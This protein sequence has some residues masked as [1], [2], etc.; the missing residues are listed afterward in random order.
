MP[1]DKEIATINDIPFWITPGALLW[2]VLMS[3]GFS[4]L[5]QVTPFVDLLTWT[6]PYSISLPVTPHTTGQVLFGMATALGLYASIL[7]HEISHTYV[8]SK[9]G[10]TVNG[11]KLWL[12]GGLST[13]DTDNIQPTDELHVS[14]AGPSVSILLGL[15]GI[16]IAG[17]LTLINTP[18]A[19]V[20]LLTVL[21]AANLAVGLFNLIPIYKMDGGRV[22]H[23]LLGY[24]YSPYR[25]TVLTIQISRAL[26]VAIIIA[27]LGIPIIQP[28]WYGVTLFSVIAGLF[29][30]AYCTK[31]LNNTTESHIVIENNTFYLSPNLH[32]SKRSTLET[33]ITNQ[34]GKT[35]STYDG[36]DY[37]VTPKPDDDTMQVLSRAN[38]TPTITPQTLLDSPATSSPREDG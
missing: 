9:R 31:A 27:S 8:A 21:A 7:L 26:G 23:A 20:T 13:I 15:T 34:G 33:V 30:Y 18:T 4:L 38:N 22:L 36:C 37:I 14:L 2:F 12:A 10:L 11:I 1:T 17:T 16:T 29:I 3:A 28:E 35:T 24:R 32:S 6:L 5:H 25:S 19:I